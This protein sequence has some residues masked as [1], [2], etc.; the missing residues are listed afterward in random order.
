MKGRS[1]TSWVA[2]K[3]LASPP[4][5]DLDRGSRFNSLWSSRLASYAPRPSTLCFSGAVVEQFRGQ[6][7]EDVLCSG[8]LG[9]DGVQG[10]EVMD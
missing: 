8:M 4:C 5:L 7:A 9:V 6:P 3:L 10:R 1:N 2:A